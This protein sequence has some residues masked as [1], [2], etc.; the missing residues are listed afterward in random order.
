MKQCPKCGQY[1]LDGDKVCASCGAPL[2]GGSANDGF[3]GDPY[4]A[5]AAP[6]AATKQEFLNLPE[7][8]KM[9]GEIKGAAIVAYICAGITA[10]VMVAY[11]GNYSAIIDVL[12]LIGLG[13]GIHLKQSRACAVALCVVG[14]I[15]VVVGVATTGSPSG[16]LVLIAGIL[17]IIYTFKLEKAWQQ[18]QAQ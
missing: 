18:Y 11:A 14:V 5:P 10:A 16:Y 1:S 17:A 13:L 4:S 12:L 9:K 8:K 3:L 6:K 15:N 7:N 2:D